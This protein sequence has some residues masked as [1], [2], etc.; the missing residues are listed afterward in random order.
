MPGIAWKIDSNGGGHV[1]QGGRSPK[2][3]E[4]R[5]PGPDGASNSRACILSCTDMEEPI[6]YPLSSNP[7]SGT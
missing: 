2:R 4:R 5:N 1:S 7:D 3:A 6:A